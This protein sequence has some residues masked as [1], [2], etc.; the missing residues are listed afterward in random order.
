M[1][2]LHT[3][4]RLSHQDILTLKKVTVERQPGTHYSNL[5]FKNNENAL[6]EFLQLKHQ[7]DFT[8]FTLVKINKK[9]NI[10]NV[11]L[12]KTRILLTFSEFVRIYSHG[13]PKLNID[14]KKK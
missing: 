11:I 6:L 10:L 1:A 7:Q 8:F 5:M 14:C 2:K 12:T 9:D 4:F 13:Q 3:Y